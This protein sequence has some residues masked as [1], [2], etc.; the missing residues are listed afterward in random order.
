MRATAPLLLLFA[1]AALLL[2][3]PPERYSFYPRCPIYALFHI[4]CPGCGGTRA[5]A[6]IL[7]GD[8]NEALHFNA[9]F[10]LA[11][12]IIVVL[13][14]L[15][16]RRFLERK[17]VRWTQPPE[18]GIYAALALTTVFTIARNL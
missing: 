5:L 8:L 2:R 4:E 13:A 14:A 1:A 16:Y 17:P 3:F 6:A 11:L 18:F 12:P 15:C 7:R 9:L 10:T